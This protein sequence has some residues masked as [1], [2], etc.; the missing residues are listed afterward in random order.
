MFCN[1]DCKMKQRSILAQM[2]L[3]Q[4]ATVHVLHLEQIK[5]KFCYTYEIVNS[6]HCFSKQGCFLIV[7]DFFSSFDCLLRSFWNLCRQSHHA[8]KMYS[9]PLCWKIIG[10]KTV[11]LQNY[12]SWLFFQLTK[13]IILDGKLSKVKRVTMVENK[14]LKVKCCYILTKCFIYM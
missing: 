5:D 3:K 10:Y 14:K 6:F 8:V 9:S 1:H 2:H 13:K 12:P 11:R 4:H 7:L